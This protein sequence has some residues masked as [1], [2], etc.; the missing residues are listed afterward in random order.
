MGIRIYLCLSGDQ[1]GMAVD[2]FGLSEVGFGKY[3]RNKQD[4]TKILKL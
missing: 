4:I 1:G 3:E 2:K